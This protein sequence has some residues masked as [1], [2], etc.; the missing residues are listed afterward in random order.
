MF[1]AITGEALGGCSGASMWSSAL[2]AHAGAD[3]QLLRKALR[4]PQRWRASREK[5]LAVRPG[6]QRSALRAL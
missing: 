5:A 1:S 4:K 2:C 3:A 6:P